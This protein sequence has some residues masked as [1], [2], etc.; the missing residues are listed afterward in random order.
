MGVIMILEEGEYMDFRVIRVVCFGDIISDLCGGMYLSN[1]F[2][3]ENFKIINV[4]KK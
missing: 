4:E 1:I 2:K 3:L